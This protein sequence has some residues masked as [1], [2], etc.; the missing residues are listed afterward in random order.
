M[1]YTHSLAG[2][3]SFLH[4]KPPPSSPAISDTSDPT[5]GNPHDVLTTSPVNTFPFD[6]QIDESGYNQATL[7]LCFD[8]D[9]LNP[10][11]YEVAGSLDETEILPHI[12][13]EMRNRGVDE[14]M[15]AHPAMLDVPYPPADV[16]TSDNWLEIPI[17]PSLEIDPPIFEMFQEGKDADVEEIIRCE[18]ELPPWD[19]SYPSPSPTSSSSSSSGSPDEFVIRSKEPT[20]SPDSPEMLV[21]MFS[22]LTCGILSIKDG[23]TENPW[24]TILLPMAADVPALHH[25]ILS[26]A[27]FHASRQDPRYRIAGL[28]HSQ[29]S[30][31]YLSNRL[32]IMRSDA[33]LATTLVLA[34]SES[35]DQETSTGIRHLHAARRLV[36]QAIANRE[37]GTDFEEMDRLKFLRNTWV[38]MDVIARITATDEE[39]LENL[40]ALFTPVYGPDGLFEELDPL[41]GCASSFFPLLGRVANLVRGIQ[42]TAHISPRAVSRAASLRTEILKWKAPSHLQQPEDESIEIAHSIKTA[43]AYRWATLLFLYQAVPMIA[44]E[45]L[46]DLA[47]RI[48]YDLVFVPT[49]S[50]LVII[51][52]FPL[53]VAGCEISGD[54][55]RLLVQERWISMIQR[56]TIGNLDRGL[57][58]I[59]EVW[60][61]RDE[62]EYSEQQMKNQGISIRDDV[63]HVPKPGNKRRTMSSPSSH[64]AIVRPDQLRRRSPD[65]VADIDP[66]TTIRGRCHWLTVMR[67][68]GWAGKSL[69]V[70]ARFLLTQIQFSSVKKIDLFGHSDPICC[71]LAMLQP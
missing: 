32:S 45:T 58:V 30:I 54:D 69:S 59:H 56:M 57:D 29:K 42:K 60:R 67:D 14:D 43:E 23:P 10:G 15:G 52:I 24:R 2:A 11:P 36:T 28:R 41:M 51:H 8:P 9:N 26:M 65:H 7:Q 63:D 70:S 50:R 1:A 5:T 19:M 49:S 6:P 48:L 25:A 31:H 44:T 4:T 18:D 55:N 62:A 13:P 16:N 3:T 21:A 46:A 71:V 17:D 68:W 38:Y 35:W 53:L 34:F 40:D 12:E 47:E 66:K 33:A 64:S 22:R 61:R 27:A 37:H 20:L 39:D